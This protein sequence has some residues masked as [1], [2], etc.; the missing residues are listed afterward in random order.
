LHLRDGAT[1]DLP[2][3]AFDI[4][5]LNPQQREAV[6]TTQGAL[7][8][9]AGA[10][11][12]KTR[13]VTCRISQM[14]K[15]GIDP[16]S[17]LAVT[18]TNKAAKEMR[19]RVGKMISKKAREVLTVS[20]FH[21][22]C[23]RILRADIE[24]LELGYKRN[25][26]I[27]SASDQS[28]LV[29]KIIVRKTAKDEK[30][31]PFMALALIGK[32][33]N[34]GED[35]PD[36]TDTLIGDVSREYRRE[37]IRL[38]VLDFDDLLVYAVKLLREHPEVRHKWSTHFQHV[39]V[40][41]FQDTNSLQMS[42][43][44]SLAETHGNVCVV[45]DDDQSI[46][47]WRGAEISNI[48][49]FER[50]FKDPLVVKLEQNYRSTTQILETANSLIIKNKGRREKELWSEISDGEPIRIIALPDDEAEAER[51]ANEIQDDQRIRKSRWED[52]AVLF[53]TNRQSRSLEMEMRRREL[54]YRVIGGQSF[55]DRREIRDILCYLQVLLNPADDVSLLRILNTPPRGIGA[56]TMTHATQTSVELKKSIHDTL[57]DPFFLS[58]VSRKAAG[59]LDDFM[60]WLEDLRDLASSTT[61][62]IRPLLEKI[63][64]DTQYSDYL[65]RT[66]KTPE[67]TSRRREGIL[68]LAASAADYQGKKGLRRFLDGTALDD[69][70]K[71]E[72]ADK[73]GISLITLHASKGLEF[74]SVWLV[75][76]E[77]GI[78]PHVRSAEEG[79]RDEERRLFYVGITRAMKS[80]TISWCRHRV[81]YGKKEACARSTFIS[82]LDDEHLVFL[83]HMEEMTAPASDDDVGDAFARMRAMLEED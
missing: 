43:L 53:R 8:I 69:D 29:R 60:T 13:T 32:A 76:L 71:D 83:D 47:G 64:E 46:Y 35:H 6:V 31:E 44:R 74:P 42:L 14:V 77:E 36:S 63:L 27:F 49:D 54:P 33:R 58:T 73:P 5:L 80:L 22:L 11:T 20:T 57:K 26:A 12:G 59:H 82:E 78:L 18:F 79:T 38:N 37:L 9:L 3:V 52:Y 56:T 50:F 62:P 81:K 7:L 67:E 10:G 75:G 48:L 25:F 21:A 28:G 51:V 68:S 1:T 61:C 66:C 24:K 65:A 39:M 72:D 34:A 19:E 17:I 4:S 45:G 2:L 16:A 15:S 23:L 55:F 30:L 41:E 70:K 40:D